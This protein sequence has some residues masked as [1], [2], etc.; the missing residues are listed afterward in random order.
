MAAVAAADAAAVVDAAALR[1]AATI[2]ACI[3]PAEPLMLRAVNTETM[4]SG[5]Y[6][7]QLGVEEGAGEDRDVGSRVRH[8][9]QGRERRR[10]T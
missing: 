6:R 1:R 7:D 3:D 9:D 10:C 2:A 5:F 4:A 8:A